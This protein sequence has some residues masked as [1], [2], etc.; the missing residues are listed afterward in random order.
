MYLGP[1][2]A[3]YSN[4]T[5]KAR[6]HKQVIIKD[7]DATKIWA[8]KKK[9]CIKGNC[10]RGFDMEDDYEI[11]GEFNLWSEAMQCRN[12]AFGVLPKDTFCAI[13]D[14]EA[15]HWTISGD[16]KMRPI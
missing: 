4:G 8:V 13:E 3:L 10:A 14:P 1:C 9:V 7:I 16:Y 2:E 11:I 5:S 15:T 12:A 6:K